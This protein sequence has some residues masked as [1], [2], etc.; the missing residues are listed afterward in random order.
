MPGLGVVGIEKE[1]ATED[2]RGLA[3]L[4]AAQEVTTVVE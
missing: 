2:V 1:D 3:A 4:L